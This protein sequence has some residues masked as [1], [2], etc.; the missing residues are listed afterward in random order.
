MNYKHGSSSL[1]LPKHLPAAYKWSCGDSLWVNFRSIPSEKWWSP[2]TKSW[3]PNG[4]EQWLW[5]LEQTPCLWKS[6][7]QQT[8]EG[9]LWAWCWRART[10]GPWNTSCTVSPEG[11]RKYHNSSYPTTAASWR[12][13]C[14]KSHCKSRMRTW[15]FQRKSHI[16]LKKS[17]CPE[18][19]IQ[20]TKGPRAMQTLLKKIEL[21]RWKKWNGPADS[22]EHKNICEPEDLNSLPKIHCRNWFLK[23]NFWRSPK[24]G[25]Q[26]RDSTGNMRRR[27]RC[28][29]FE[30]GLLWSPGWLAFRIITLPSASQSTRIP[31]GSH[32]TL[33]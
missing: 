16:G 6:R 2:N 14:M 3:N 19:E 11:F 24:G 26:G 21:S 12:R 9:F 29:S 18:K 17:L 5:A 7:V 32:H 31:I 15:K 23:T 25:G 4:T 33:V 27:Q 8:K 22:S 10:S 28:F 1:R 30:T 20:M 13:Y